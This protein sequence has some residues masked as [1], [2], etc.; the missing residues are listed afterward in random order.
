M[1]T[2]VSQEGSTRHGS[3]AGWPS[4][5]LIDEIMREGAWRMLVTALLAEADAYCAQVGEQRDEDGRRLVVRNGYAE[6]RQVMTAA[7]AVEVK[8][9][10]V[11][12]KRIDEASGEWCRFSSAILPP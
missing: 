12:D 2:V 7:G 11:N 8:A 5:S 9:P 10:R 3:A 1:L 6:P 4:S